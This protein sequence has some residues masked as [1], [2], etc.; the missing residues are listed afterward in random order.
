MFDRFLFKY[1]IENEY[2]I[3]VVYQLTKY[4]R[5]WFTKIR[6]LSSCKWSRKVDEISIHLALLCRNVNYIKDVHCTP[7]NK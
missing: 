7:T 3:F 2:S 5:N 4:C 6:D 1:K